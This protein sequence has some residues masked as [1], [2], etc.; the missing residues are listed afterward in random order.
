MQKRL[1][2]QYGLGTAC[3]RGLKVQSGAKQ[4]VP[5]IKTTHKGDDKTKVL[6]KALI[7]GEKKCGTTSLY[8][9]L[10]DIYSNIKIPSR[11]YELQFFSRHYEKGIEFYMKKLPTLANNNDIIIE[12]SA[13][14]FR[15]PGTAA[16]IYKHIPDVRL[17]LVVCD[18]IKRT[19]SDFLHEQ[20]TGRISKNLTLED[21]ITHPNGS[22]RV[23][24]KIIQT[25]LY[26]E[27]IKQWLDIFP[28]AQLL[29]VNGQSLISDPVSSLDAIVDHLELTKRN[30]SEIFYKPENS[31][32]YCWKR[33]CMKRK[34]RKHPV[35]S[36]ILLKFLQELFTRSNEVF[37]NLTKVRF[38]WRMNTAR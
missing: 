7:I 17:I 12:K 14:Y 38:E 4:V 18:P 29:I 1:F 33:N 21:Y 15:S 10:D 5:T 2:Q 19:M 28:R 6:P 30:H 36:E 22:Y 32:Y 11:K 20:R 37:F 27:H 8:Y 34:E 13:S 24:N 26:S 16:R 31:D 23:G 9:M 3:P 35:I 25:S